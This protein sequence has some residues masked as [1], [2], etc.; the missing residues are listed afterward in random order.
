MNQQ[1]QNRPPLKNITKSGK[2]QLKL[3]APKKEKI[4]EY[5]GTLSASILFVDAAGNCLSRFY[6]T[7]YPAS[8]ATLIGKFTGKYMP[9]IKES[10]TADQLEAYISQAHMCIAEIDVEVMPPKE[11]SKY[12]SYKFKTILPVIGNGNA[13]VPPP[14]DDDE[15]QAPA[16]VE[17]LPF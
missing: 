11:G 16:M 17:P 3:I 12:N 7:K 5:G 14:G 2:Y 15:P 1:N 9:P 6:G 13:G 4:R 10:A 8:L